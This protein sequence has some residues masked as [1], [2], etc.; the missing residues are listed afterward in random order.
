LEAAALRDYK[1][2]LEKAG[3]AEATVLMRAEAAMTEAQFDAKLAN[4]LP[5]HIDLQKRVFL[6]LSKPRS[7][8]EILNAVPMDRIHWIPVIFSLLNSRLIS[9]PGVVSGETD[10]SAEAF[11]NIAE[12]IRTADKG[13]LQPD[14]GML[15]YPMFL[16][17]AEKE[18]DR[19]V[20][21]CIAMFEFNVPGASITNEALKSVA[22]CF[23][24]TKKSYEIITFWQPNRVLMLLPHSQP[25]DS[26]A[27]IH[28][29]LDLVAKQDASV[30]LSLVCGVASAPSDG[31]KLADV[32]AA[33]YRLVKKAQ[34]TNV[35]V[36]ANT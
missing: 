1:G 34:Q 20:S 3:V 17:F 4:G 19:R 11:A 30:G 16:S 10:Q 7:L 5:M 27:R 14:S 22:S 31:T 28:S 2:F 21:F 23:N 15:S 6:V 12:L 29:F 9:A 24:S 13:L 36:L 33:S 32:L 35:R 26:V 18:F 25:A 8:T